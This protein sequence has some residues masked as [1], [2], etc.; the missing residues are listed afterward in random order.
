MS[1][2]VASVKPSMIWLEEFITSLTSLEEL[3]S[4]YMTIL[5]VWASGAAAFLTTS[6]SAVRY[7]SRTDASPIF[8]WASAF[9]SIASASA[10]PTA[11]IP[12]ASFILA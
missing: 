4:P 7:I 8:F 2:P 5:S 3:P 11:R 12:S 9:F 6:G 1:T 10:R